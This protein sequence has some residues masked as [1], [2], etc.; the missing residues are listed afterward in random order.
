MR[1]L[2]ILLLRSFISTVLPVSWL[3]G[4]SA[5]KSLIL[6]VDG[7]VIGGAEASG[8]PDLL[9]GASDCREYGKHGMTAV[10]F[11][12]EAVLQA[13]IITSNSIKLSFTFPQ[14]LYSFNC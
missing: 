3:K 10:T 5:L 6:G 1:K 4:Y 11:R 12:A 9:K 14:P 2:W 8:A 7:T 13:W